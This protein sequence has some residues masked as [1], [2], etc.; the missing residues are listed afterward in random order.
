MIHET[1]RL[2]AYERVSCQRWNLMECLIDR[3]TDVTAVERRIY[4]VKF[5]RDKS[6]FFRSLPL[7]WQLIAKHNWSKKYQ[8]WSR[9]YHCNLIA[10]SV[11]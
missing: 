6:V 8:D 7:F 9:N 10:K 1:M 2:G 3:P 5:C 11:Q 4:A